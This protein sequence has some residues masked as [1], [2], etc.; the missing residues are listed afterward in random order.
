MPVRAG[1]IRRLLIGEGP[2]ALKAM[3]RPIISA[4]GAYVP[5]HP[6]REGVSAFLHGLKGML[7]GEQPVAQVRQ[8]F[9]QGGVF[10]RGGLLHGPLAWDPAFS[11]AVE[12]HGWV[13]A[14]KNPKTRMAAIEGTLSAGIQPAMFVGLPA[15]G[16]YRATQRGKSPGAAIGEGLGF[17]AA[18]PFGAAS[19]IAG[20]GLGRVGEHFLPAPELPSIESMGGLQGAFE[21]MNSA[22]VLTPNTVA[23]ER[24]PL[25]H[26]YS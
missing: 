12:Q 4:S 19:N 15:Y 8:R 7:V 6:P 22:H 13:G 24:A 11:K 21:K 9:I 17:A 1:P 25:L 20:L 26:R 10:G 23:D 2:A 3:E 18:A 5:T 14:L 16:A